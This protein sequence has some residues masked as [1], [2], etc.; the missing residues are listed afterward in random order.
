MFISLQVKILGSCRDRFGRRCAAWLCVLFSYLSPHLS[1][2][3]LLEYL[4]PADSRASAQPRLSVSLDFVC[5]CVWLACLM[6]VML[7]VRLR[8][9]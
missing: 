7:S 2:V 6:F 9:P 8:L 3:R 5:V 4:R 1:A